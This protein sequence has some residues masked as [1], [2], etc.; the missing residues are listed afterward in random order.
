MGIQ[1]CQ[2]L[3]PLADFLKREQRRGLAGHH[4]NWPTV[5]HLATVPHL[6]AVP[7]CSAVVPDYLVGAP[8]GSV[9]G[10]G[11]NL[12]RRSL[13]PLNDWICKR[14]KSTVQVPINGKS[15]IVSEFLSTDCSC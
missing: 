7:R 5:P 10:W 11:W 3:F 12:V 8:T 2:E 13:K 4:A 14:T 9:G 6:P 15:G 1:A